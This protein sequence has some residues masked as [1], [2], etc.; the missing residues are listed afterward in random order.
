VKL[1][2]RIKEDFFYTGISWISSLCTRS[3][4]VSIGPV[5]P[6]LHTFIFIFL[7]VYAVY[8]EW[9]IGRQLLCL[10][11]KNTLCSVNGIQVVRTSHTF[12]DFA[13]ILHIRTNNKKENKVLFN[14]VF[15]QLLECVYMHLLSSLRD[16][17]RSYISVRKLL[18]N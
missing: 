16:I 15:I 13:Y 9:D 2:S 5:R 17:W 3:A 10:L 18:T 4:A 14:W 11:W 1:L 8:N 6:I 12:P 7:S